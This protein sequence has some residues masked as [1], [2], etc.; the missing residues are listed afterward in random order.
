MESQVLEARA[1]SSVDGAELTA[2]L[3]KNVGIWSDDGGKASASR[4]P[5]IGRDQVVHLL[6]GLHR[7]AETAGLTRDGLVLRR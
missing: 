5:L 2:L 7:T 3:A 4:R 1:F 6:I